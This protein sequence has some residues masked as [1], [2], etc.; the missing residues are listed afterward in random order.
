MWLHATATAP[1]VGQPPCSHDVRGMIG[2]ILYW[3]TVLQNDAIALCFRAGVD[4]SKLRPAESVLLNLH[5]LLEHRQA[6]IG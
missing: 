2:K 3:S 4:V 5:A 6:Q 1:F